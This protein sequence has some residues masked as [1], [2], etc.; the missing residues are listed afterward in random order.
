[1]AKKNRCELIPLEL[2][3]WRKFQ[4]SR[5][6]QAYIIMMGFDVDS[7]EKNLEKFSLM[8]LTHTPFDASG[9]IVSL[10]DICGQKRKVLP[11]DC[12]GLVLVWTQ[13]RVSLNVLQLM[14]GLTYTNLSVYLR[15]G[16]RLVVEVF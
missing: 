13:M 4:A 2:S 14:F 3:P 6:D 16:I 7:F 10:D 9:M 15:F 1:M 8:Y 11:A 12:L 5:N